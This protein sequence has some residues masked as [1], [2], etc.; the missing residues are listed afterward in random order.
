MR[1]TLFR[2]LRTGLGA[3]MLALGIVGLSA[4]AALA[5]NACNVTLAAATATVDGTKTLSLNENGALTVSGVSCTGDGTVTTTSVTLTG[6]AN[7]DT[8]TF[9]FAEQ[10][11]GIS[12]SIDLGNGSD[13]VILT[14]TTGG[15]EQNEIA[16]GNGKVS[17]DNVANET[18]D[19]TALTYVEAITVNAGDGDDLVL[20]DG[21]G[22]YTTPLT[23]PMTVNGGAGDDI[24]VGG[25]ANDPA[26]NG[27]GGDDVLV[28]GQ[29]NDTMNGGANGGG[30]DDVAYDNASFVG[31]AT[32]AGIT[33][34]LGTTSAQITG[35]AGSDTVTNVENVQGSTFDDT[36]RGNASANTLQGWEGDDTLIGLGGNDVINGDAGSDTAS[37]DNVTYA[38]AASA[39][40]T[41]DLSNASSQNTVGAGSDTVT[42]VEN[43]IGSSFGDT[44]TGDS[45]A[46]VL[47]GLGGTD[48]LKGAAGNDTLDGGAGNGD[49][50]AGG[51]G[52]D[53]FNGGAGTGDTVSY[54]DT[55]A[56][57][58][59]TTGITFSLAVLS[60]TTQTTGGAGTDTLVGGV[61]NLTGSSKADRLT[62]DGGANVLQGGAQNDTL[63]GGSGDDTLVGGAGDD[64]FTG[65][66]GVDLVSYDATVYAGA[67]GA[68]ITFNLS[69]C[70]AQATAG[71]GSDRQTCPNGKSDIENLTGSAGNDTL[72][73]NVL[74]NRIL[75]LDGQDTIYGLSGNDYL[76]GGATIGGAAFNTLNGGTGTDYCGSTGGAYLSV[77]TACEIAI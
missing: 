11:D 56:G 70:T 71:S 24:I 5:V 17:L 48:T 55:F 77:K 44:L 10:F 22:A 14:T 8:V 26:L 76:D 34:D 74:A 29:G 6:S 36:L 37:Y 18:A 47:S 53:A 73:G 32:A 31:A 43:V 59:P 61:E 60:P 4:P 19:I 69:L 9:A 30:G 75:G 62:G 28:G 67:A 64:V 16:M 72:T 39:G 57:V 35:G 7:N 51:N 46:N 41:L 21:F 20:G 66:S 49:Q 13:T 68:A 1:T 40:I 54:D 3:L 52:D 58:V 23:I 25:S 65:G 33:F 2:R 27:D 38:G 42:N 50:L 63:G 15:G 12:I 45:V